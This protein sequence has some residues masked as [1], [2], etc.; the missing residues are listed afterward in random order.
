M[1]QWPVLQ[2]GRLEAVVHLV[3]HQVEVEEEDLDEKVVPHHLEVVGDHHHNNAVQLM[4]M[5][6]KIH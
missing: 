3:D 5:M 4:N 6:T 1:W 2:A